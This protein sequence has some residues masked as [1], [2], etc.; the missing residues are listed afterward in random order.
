MVKMN[1]GA[2]LTHI[3]KFFSSVSF[4]NM[5]IMNIYCK[6]KVNSLDDSEDNFRVY[7]QNNVTLRVYQSFFMKW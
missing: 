3:V 6:K 5:V 7:F 1:K 2:M 4:S